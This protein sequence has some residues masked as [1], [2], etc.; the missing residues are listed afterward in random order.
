MSLR[1][2]HSTKSRISLVEQAW[3][4]PCFQASLINLVTTS[5]ESLSH[6][7]PIIDKTALDP[8]FPTQK[9]H[10]KL[11]EELGRVIAAF[12]FLEETL[13]K[14]IFVYA[15]KRLS[16][17]IHISQERKRFNK[18]LLETASE[19]LVKLIGKFE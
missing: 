14:A 16:S 2:F 7:S 19:P 10:G 1:I 5:C 18:Q 13:F 17:D 11:W 8:L 6:T 12:G 4:L 9:H 3:I 15:E